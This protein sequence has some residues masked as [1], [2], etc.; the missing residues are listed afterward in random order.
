MHPNPIFKNASLEQ[1]TEFAR[2]RGFGTL[3]INSTFE[4]NDENTTVIGPLL[5]HIPFVLDNS[6]KILVAHL[7]R[8]NPMLKLLEEEMPGVVAVAGPDSYV[9]PDWYEIEDQVPTWNYV[10]VHIRGHIKR[11]A[12]YELPAILDQ[13][14][15]QFEKRLTPKPVW[16]RDKID[17]NT[18]ARMMKM[19][20]PISMRVSNIEGTWKLSQNKLDEARI[21]AANEVSEHGIGIQIRE[22]ANLMKDLPC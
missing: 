15:I 9:S 18:L 2:Q 11:L 6:G 3:A 8:S 21:N 17:E 1:N 12:D 14:S 13:L 5:S 19:I 10:A 4:T 7:I 22:L 20:V 16:T